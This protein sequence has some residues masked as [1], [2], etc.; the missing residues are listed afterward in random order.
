LMS[1]H[2]ML[3]DRAFVADSF[4]AAPMAPRRSR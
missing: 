4:G 1:E 3:R 2:S